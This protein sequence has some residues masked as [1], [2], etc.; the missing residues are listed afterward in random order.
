MRAAAGIAHRAD[1]ASSFAQCLKSGA[2]RNEASWFNFAE[3]LLS[4]VMAVSI[5]TFSPAAFVRWKAILVHALLA[6]AVAAMGPG[7]TQQYFSSVNSQ[8]AAVWQNEKAETSVIQICAHC[9][10]TYALGLYSLNF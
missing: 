1:P 3:D 8:P 4:R 6:A 10:T 7:M 9:T 5:C 2:E